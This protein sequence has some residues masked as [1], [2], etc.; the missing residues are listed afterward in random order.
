MSQLCPSQHIRDWFFF[1]RVLNSGSFCS[2]LRLFF[3]FFTALAQ[4]SSKHGLWF[5][6]QRCGAVSIRFSTLL[7]ST[8]FFSP[9]VFFLAQLSFLI[10]LCFVRALVDIFEL[11]SPRAIDS[12]CYVR[13]S[14]P[15]AVVY[16]LQL[17]SFAPLLFDAVPSVFHFTFSFLPFSPLLF[18]TVSMRS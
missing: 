7:F 4:C 3:S 13:R 16:V 17:F 2:S 10:Y 5:S 15:Y 6:A 11:V 1:R 8:A 18:N 9:V 14:S 12:S